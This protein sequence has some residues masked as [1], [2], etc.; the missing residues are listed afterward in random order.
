VEAFNTDLQTV[1]REEANRFLAEVSPLLQGDLNAE[2]AEGLRKWIQTT[3]KLQGNRPRLLM[4]LELLMDP[5]DQILKATALQ[6]LDQLPT[7]EEDLRKRLAR[8]APGDPDGRVNLDQLRDRLA[9]R[10][11]RQEM[12]VS[13]D[14]EVPAVLEQKVS[15][16]NWMG[17]LFMGVFG[18][19][20][21]AFT[22]VHCVLMIGGMAQAFGWMAL[23]LLAFY[24]IFFLVGF[25]MLFGAA[26]SCA[27]ESIRLE[28]RDL[29]ITYQL[30]GIR[31]HR[32]FT[33]DPTAKITIG[34]PTAKFKNSSDSDE[35]GRQR[36]ILLTTAEGKEVSIGANATEAQRD[37]LV[38]K[39]SAYLAAQ[40]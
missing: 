32:R 11:A 13:T 6:A 30:F 38:K 9:E 31:Y 19:G 23:G 15:D 36:A 39:L 29:T 34:K 25:G 5:S 14:L 3:E 12:G 4:D 18:L 24:S 28:G 22:T 16:P 26:A 37:A 40:S 33:L 2:N 17:G 27:T 10:A 21:T 20:W 7:L 8:L 35:S 1:A